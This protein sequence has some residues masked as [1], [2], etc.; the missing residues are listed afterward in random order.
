MAGYRDPLKVGMLSVAVPGAGHVYAGDAARGMT[1]FLGVA[2]GLFLF[3]VPGVVIWLA[4]IGD[5][6]LMT[7]QRNAR[8]MPLYLPTEPSPLPFMPVSIKDGSAPTRA[9]SDGPESRHRPR[10]TAP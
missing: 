4:A 8:C 10:P 1:Y 2:V 3:V 9:L 5:A 7:W 6:V